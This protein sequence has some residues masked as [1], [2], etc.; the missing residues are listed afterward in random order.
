MMLVGYNMMSVVGVVYGLKALLYN[1]VGDI[2]V[3]CG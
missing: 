1:R 3:L 2:G